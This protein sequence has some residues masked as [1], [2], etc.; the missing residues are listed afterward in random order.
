MQRDC[1]ALSLALLLAVLLCCGISLSL[2]F[3][4]IAG[5]AACWLQPCR[6]AG[7]T[8][9]HTW[10]SLPKSGSPWFPSPVTTGGG[11]ALPRPPQEKHRAPTNSAA[12]DQQGA[13]PQRMASHPWGRSREGQHPSPYHGH[14]SRS[15]R[16]AS[17]AAAAAPATPM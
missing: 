15:Q 5:T 4:S 3:M 6:V 11:K 12:S 16:I 9:R 2:C 10:G 1:L 14:R 7:P 17:G 13:Y 8:C